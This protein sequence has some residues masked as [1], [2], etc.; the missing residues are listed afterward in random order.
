MQ[1]KYVIAYDLGT[2]GLK[3]SLHDASGTTLAFL[4]CEYPTLYY[5]E[6]FHEQRPEDWWQAI[7]RST[8]LLLDKVKEQNICKEQICA[9]AISGHSLVGIPMDREGRPLVGQVPIWSDGRAKEQA[10]RF[11][12]RMTTTHGMKQ[13]ATVIRLPV[14]RSSRSC[15]CAKTSRKYTKRQPIF[16]A[17]RIISI[18]D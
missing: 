13:P 6:V 12:K 2:G 8:R 3:A 10:R 11:L 7:C 5:K 15:G 9:L 18:S 4:V 1:G 16:W 17:P 14:I